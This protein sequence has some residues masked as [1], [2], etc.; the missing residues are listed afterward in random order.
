MNRVIRACTAIF[1]AS[2]LCGLAAAQSQSSLSEYARDQ[3]KNKPQHEKA[4]PSVYDN[5]NLPSTDT[6]NVVGSAGETTSGVDVAER[7]SDVKPGPEQKKKDAGEIK[8][9]QSPE[10]RQKAYAEWTKRINKRRDRVDQLARELDSLEENPPM[11]V[12]VLHLWPDDK[13]F[14]TNYRKTK[15]AGSS[16]R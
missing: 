16:K 9:G 4:A 13:L 3:R 6:I 15:C 11:S 1:V 2:S 7:V 10:E 8:I 14:P 5:D 12:L